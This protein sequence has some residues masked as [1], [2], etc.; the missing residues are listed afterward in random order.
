MMK[1]PVAGAEEEEKK[2]ES[3][4][5]KLEAIRYSQLVER[6]LMT[7]K[8]ECFNIVKP[9]KCKTTDHSDIH[10]KYCLV[11]KIYR[12]DVDKF[13]QFVHAAK[14]IKEENKKSNKQLNLKIKETKKDMHQAMYELFQ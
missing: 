9:W 11:D 8:Y 4:V 14:D 7:H 10:K 5:P 12:R 6:Y 13:E 2:A 3:A 1:M